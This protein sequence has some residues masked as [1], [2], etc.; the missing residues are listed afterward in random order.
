MPSLG[1]ALPSSKKSAS[2][3]FSVSIARC[4]GRR[5]R[6]SW[7]TRAIRS[8]SPRA[9]ASAFRRSKTS[10]VSSRRPRV[11]SPAT[12]HERQ[13]ERFLGS[14]LDLAQGRSGAAIVDER[15]EL[16]ALL[17]EG[18]FGAV[19]EVFDR[20]RGE[21]VALKLLHRASSDALLRFKREFR[22]LARLSDPS[23]VKLYDLHGDG[24]RWYFTM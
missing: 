7:M 24:D 9:Y 16:G 22:S 5:S 19:Y 6:A 10:S 21:R 13:R 8:R 12:I 4:L 18:S 20:S 17:G 2:S 23:F 14:R 3:S 15:Y 11:S 1:F